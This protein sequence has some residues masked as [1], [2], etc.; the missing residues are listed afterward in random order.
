LKGERGDKVKDYLTKLLDAL[1]ARLIAWLLD[2]LSDPIDFLE[3]SLQ[4]W[5]QGADEE[6][7]GSE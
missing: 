6:E 5:G 7:G 1:A 3:T 2:R 4:E